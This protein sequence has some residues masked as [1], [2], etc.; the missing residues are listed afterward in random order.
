M[1]SPSK[2]SSYGPS[3]VRKSAPLGSLNN[4]L[5]SLSLNSPS[6][7][8]SLRDTI[9]KSAHQPKK[10][11]ISAAALAAL[12]PSKKRA[13]PSKKRSASPTK[14]IRTG[15]DQLTQT[16]GNGDSTQEYGTRTSPVK[17]AKGLAAGGG[18]G[19]MDVVGNDWDASLDVRKSP[20]KK[21]KHVSTSI[22]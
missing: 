7:A 21:G 13:S 18:L 5:T 16:L 22:G 17:A 1:T 4:T 11:V 14:S 9:H 3:P 8:Q 20:T 2:T 19:R 12:A 6:R 10:T 15:D